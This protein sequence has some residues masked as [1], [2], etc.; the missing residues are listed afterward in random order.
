M[1]HWFIIPVNPEP[2]A[3]GSLGVGK[4]G[5]K[6]YPYMSPNPQLVAYKQAIVE[7]LEHVAKLPVG[8]Y[9]LRFFFWRR[10]DDYETQSG[11]RHRK[12]VADS[13]NLQKATEDALQG[14]LFD[15]DRNVRDVRS[16]VVEQG[17][18]VEAKVILYAEVWSGFD[19][20]EIPVH[21]WDQ[22]DE[23]PSLELPSDNSWPPKMGT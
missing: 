19:P 21:I 1:G 15:N 7:S 3:V 20:D 9:S 4:K 6:P 13:T 2:W 11:R 12:H 17:A 14:I 18:D 16:V 23:T 5:G 22:V 8:E 10:L